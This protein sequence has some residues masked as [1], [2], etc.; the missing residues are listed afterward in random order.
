MAYGGDPYGHGVLIV[1]RAGESPVDMAKQNEDVSVADIPETHEYD[2]E[3]C[4]MQNA[5]TVLNVIREIIRNRRYINH[6]R[7]G[8]GES[9]T[10]GSEGGRRKSAPVTRGNSPAAY[11]TRDQRTDLGHRR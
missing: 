4:R 6:W 8:C 11:L 1:V 3:V 7:A 9:C 2:R 5:E 10:S